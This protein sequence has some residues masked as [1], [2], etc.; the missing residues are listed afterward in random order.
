MLK[1]VG[2]GVGRTGT[3]SLKVAVEQ[4][5]GGTCHHM[6][7]V[8]AHPEQV[9]VWIDAI[10]GRPVDWGALM[11]DYTAQV[12]WP[13]ASFWPELAAAN[14]DALVILS[15]RD[16]DAWFTSC[17]NTIFGGMRQMVE[18]GNDWMAAMLRLLAER[19]DDRV[20]DHDA[21]VAAFERHN[22]QVREGVPRERLLEWTER[23]WSR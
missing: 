18:D 4:L 7:E 3:H 23:S 21:M 20:E 15:L 11:K 19:F 9:P 12:D 16:P 10:D 17:T 5:L 6:V 13:G 22:D 2:A 14:P 1:V 8:F